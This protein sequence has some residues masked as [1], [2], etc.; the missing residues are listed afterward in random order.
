[1]SYRKLLT[2]PDELRERVLALIRE[3][4]EAG[5]EGRI[6]MKM[7]SLVDQPFIDALY[8]APSTKRRRRASRW[9]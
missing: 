5:S 1:M 7:N 9:T 2:A 4:T 8:E 6:V 3:E